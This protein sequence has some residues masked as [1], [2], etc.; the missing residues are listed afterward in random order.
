ML[1]CEPGNFP[2]KGPG[3]SLSFRRVTSNN[4]DPDPEVVIDIINLCECLFVS[5]ETLQ[6]C[7]GLILYTNSRQ[8]CHGPNM[9]WVVM[10]TFTV[11]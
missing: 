8:H 1:I 5:Q 10:F 7:Y 2:T 6:T 3:E 9:L 11:A 4:P